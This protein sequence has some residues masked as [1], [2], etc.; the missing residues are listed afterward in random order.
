[1]LIYIKQNNDVCQLILTGFYQ[2]SAKDANG[3][4]ERKKAVP[5]LV[6]TA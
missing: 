3:N 6:W 4:P 1:M 5:Q 2:I